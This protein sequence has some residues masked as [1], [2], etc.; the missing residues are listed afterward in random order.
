MCSSTKGRMINQWDLINNYVGFGKL[1]G[2]N[3]Y[4]FVVAL[5]LQLIILNTRLLFRTIHNFRIKT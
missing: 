3:I 4:N 2:A 1:K 5:N